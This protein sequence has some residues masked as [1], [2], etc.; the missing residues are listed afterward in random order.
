VAFL[1]APGGSNKGLSEWEKQLLAQVVSDQGFAPVMPTAGAPP[2]PGVPA[3]TST[4][5]KVPGE[6]RIPGVDPDW[7]ALIAGDP[8]LMQTEADLDLFGN[9]L[10]E[11]ARAAI[12]KAVIGAGLI[13]QGATGD[14]DAA[15]IEAAKANRMSAAAELESQRN[16]GTTD[17]Q[18]ALAARGILDSGALTGGQQRIQ[19]GY[20]K[21]TTSILN[22]LLDLISGVESDRTEQD[23]SLRQQRA[24]MR[25]AA[26]QRIFADPRYQ[27]GGSSTAKL[28][29]GSGLYVTADGRWY[30]VNGNRVNPPGAGAPQVAASMSYTPP[31]A[32]S[33]QPAP[34]APVVSDI[35]GDVGYKKPILMY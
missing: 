12:R 22:Q 19:E 21:G 28:D 2:A 10:N 5:V 15:T 20:E 34:G 30:D 8:T 23:F 13:P 24:A 6:V 33:Y 17:L 27:Q 18:A 35:Y 3:G 31:P 26:A 16:R 4:G 29:P 32:P 11:A 25:Q 9:R 7:N 1:P 14:I